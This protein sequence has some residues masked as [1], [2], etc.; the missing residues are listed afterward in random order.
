VDEKTASLA[1][2]AVVV[3]LRGAPA[4]Y[5]RSVETALAAGA[6]AE[7]VVDTLTA[8]APAVG[9]ARVVSAA[10]RLALSLGYDID[11]AL[12]SLDEPRRAR[13]P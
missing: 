10:P 6:T 11:D 3:A 7:E 13:R 8:V 2:V 5:E 1:R 12:E 4:A 9:L